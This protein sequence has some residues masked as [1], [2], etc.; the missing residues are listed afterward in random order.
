MPWPLWGRR[1]RRGSSSPLLPNTCMS[2]S[3]SGTSI[4]SISSLGSICWSNEIFSRKFSEKEFRFKVLVAIWCVT[5][6]F[7]FVP[8]IALAPVHAL[9]VVSEEKE[10]GSSSLTHAFLSANRRV[11]V[12]S[13]WIIAGLPSKGVWDF[14][15]QWPWGDN[16]LEPGMPV[17]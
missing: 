10:G 5:T 14:S 9:N 13:S 15:F 16:R 4:G 3:A 11:L 6:L 8:I 1:R 17:W 2:L 7:Y 12:L